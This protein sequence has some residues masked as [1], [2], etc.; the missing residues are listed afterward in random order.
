MHRVGA[1]DWY[2]FDHD[3]FIGLRDNLHANM[4]L[5]V[6]RFGEQVASAGLLSETCGIVQFHLAGTRSGFEDS[7]AIKLLTHFARDW[8]KARGNDVFHLGGGVGAANDSLFYFKSG[9]SKHRSVFQTWR[10]IIDPQ[11][12]CDLVAERRMN[13][14]TKA[15]GPI[16]YFP[17]YRTEFVGRCSPL[18]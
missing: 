15:E 16:T 14:E 12:Y 6:V 1:A 9:F 8:G 4:H 5:L 17:E 10:L 7:D 11:T 13:A 18:H 3:H 2:F